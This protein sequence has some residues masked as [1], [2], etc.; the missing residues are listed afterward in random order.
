M[1]VALKLLPNNVVDP[2]KLENVFSE[3]IFI[4]LLTKNPQ[5]ALHCKNNFCLFLLGRCENNI[6]P[7]L[8]IM[9]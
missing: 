6:T 8:T 2:C 5:G 1:Q 4:G 7:L 3:D 9:A